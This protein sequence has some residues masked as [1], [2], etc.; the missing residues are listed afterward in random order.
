MFISSSNLQL[1]DEEFIMKQTI[2][3][4][5]KYLLKELMNEIKQVIK[6]IE[7]FNGFNLVILI[8]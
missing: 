3:R 5:S 8:D 1:N 2:L 6:T 7:T 4:K